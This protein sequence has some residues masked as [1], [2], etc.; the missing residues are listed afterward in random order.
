MARVL[1]IDDEPAVAGVVVRLLSRSGYEVEFAEGG[2][3]GL[4]AFE[5]HEPDLVITDMN[6]PDMHGIAVMQEVRKL[7]P[8]MPVIALTGEAVGPG[9]PYLSQAVLPEAIA[10]L[11]K[12]FELSDLLEAVER[13]LA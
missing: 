3:A 13:A 9:E 2:R 6:M 4:A 7:R 12:P 8:D 5:E 10:V 11:G 1:I